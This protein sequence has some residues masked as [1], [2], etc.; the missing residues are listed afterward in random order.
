MFPKSMY[1]PRCRRFITTQREN[2]ARRIAMTAAWN[3]KLR[4]FLCHYT[5]LKVEELDFTDLWYLSFDHVIPGKLGDLVVAALWVNR[6]K[7]F[8]TEAEFRAVLKQLADR[9]R[10]GTPFD[11]GVIDHRRFASRARRLASMTV[12]N[13]R[14]F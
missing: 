6:M 14:S 12:I 11:T 7:S 2:A 5:G 4:A 10:H 8:L 3:A 9:F 13:P 1:C